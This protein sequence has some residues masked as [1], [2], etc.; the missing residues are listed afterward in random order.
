MPKRFC[1]LSDEDIY[2]VY[3]NVEVNQMH[4]D[5]NIEIYMNEQ[6]SLLIT[7]RSKIFFKSIHEIADWC[8]NF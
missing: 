7:I 8:S 5:E 6:I 3:T 2:K 1:G 4:I